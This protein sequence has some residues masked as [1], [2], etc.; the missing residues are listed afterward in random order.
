MHA[1]ERLQQA[2]ELA[3]ALGYDVRQDWLDGNGGGH[4]LVRG[5]KLLM[6]DLAQTHEEQF[7]VVCNALRGESH[8]NRMEMSDELAEAL[9]VRS[10]A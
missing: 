6:L 7:A 5:R 2:L 3:E 10:V 9:D 8:L 1:V 4:C